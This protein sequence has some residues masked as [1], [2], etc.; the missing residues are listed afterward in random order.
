MS[1]VSMSLSLGGEARTL[2][3]LDLI[4]ERLADKTPLMRDISAQILTSTQ[5]RFET[6]SGPDGVAWKPSIRALATGGVTL[7]DTARL[8]DSFIAANTSDTAEVGSNVEY[9]PTH[10]FGRTK[11]EQVK[12]HARRIEQA[13]GKPLRF[14]VYQSVGEYSRK[15][16][17]PARPML[18]LSSDDQGDILDLAERHLTGD[19]A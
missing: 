8:R 1:G 19:L 10:Q 6:Q 2:G 5:L 3:A 15:P 12:P 17:I 11:V 9:A 13:F 14:A 4:A 7:T 16:N 18:G